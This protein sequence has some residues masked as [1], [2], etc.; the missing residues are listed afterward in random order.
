MWAIGKAV[1]L[2]FHNYSPERAEAP[3]FR[4]LLKRPWAVDRN[5]A[6]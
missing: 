2:E 5:I 6:A 3:K 4:H 1:R